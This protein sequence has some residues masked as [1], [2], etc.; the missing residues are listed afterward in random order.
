MTIRRQPSDFHVHE[1][2]APWF[3]ARM[4]SPE[5]RPPT[6]AHA[7]Y[8]LRKHDLS[9]PEAAGAFGRA[10]AAN[11]Q[12]QG[13]AGGSPTASGPGPARLEYA[14]LKDKH[15]HTVQHVTWHAP[16]SG[17]AAEAPPALEGPGWGAT[18]R[19]WAD[20]PIDA[21]AIA[22]NRFTIV[23]RD[24]TK[25]ASEEM[26][27]RNQAL[28]A[29]EN[30]DGPLPPGTPR[31]LLIVNYFGAQRFGSAR[32]GE[33]FAAE[34][35][36]AHDFLGAIRL[37]VATPARKDTGRQRTFTRMAA[38]RWGDWP[39]MAS[40]LPPLP[41]R[42]A[43]ERLA[44]GEA[45]A[46]AFAALP[47]FLQQMSVE[48]F[49]SL[50]WNDVARR[51]ADTL[52]AQAGM[53]PLIRDDDFGPLLFP[54]ASCVHARALDTRVPM[55]ARGL[56]PRPPWGEAAVAALAQRGLK[57]EDLHVPSLRRPAFESVQR[58][59]FVSAEAFSMSRAEEDEL[60]R[61]GSG[62]LKRTLAFTLPRGAYATV[63]LRAL[64]Q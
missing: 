57:M 48:A 3:L 19:G 14:G 4:V 18:L 25:R 60:A 42:K 38:D 22:G 16:A 21:Q 24:L 64:G 28:H 56:T 12:G 2:L 43:F 6:H 29:R 31:R 8:E 1:Q 61:A 15:A 37:L 32:H 39:R 30:A 5:T 55:L 34:R 50:L 36:I 58:P 40:E 62:R 46:S 13:G 47:Y 49:Q 27:R 54:P 52:C 10:L 17:G 41:E 20:L 51:L 23:V 63:A 11:T 9:T 44:A 33:G 45:P 26:H 53:N 59:L 35:I 7:V